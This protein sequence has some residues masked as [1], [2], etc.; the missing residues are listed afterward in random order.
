M[1]A[2]VVAARPLAL[3]AAG[4]G[5]VAPVFAPVISDVSVASRPAQPPDES[6]YVGRE[7]PDLLIR[8]SGGAIRLSKLWAQGPVVLSLVFA[9][10][11]GVCS[12]YLRALRAADAS[13]GSP[14]DLRRVVLSFDPRDTVADMEG[15]ARHLGVFGLDGWTFGIADPADIDRLSDALGFWFTWDDG[16]Q[17]F[18]HPAML[19]GIRR[20][21]VAR[22]LIGESVTP[23][24][25]AEVVR[26]GRGEFVASYPLPSAT[27]WRCFDYDPATGQA[28]LSWGALILIVP[29]LAAVTLTLGLFRRSVSSV[30]S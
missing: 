11:A 22:L 26:E 21:R 5:P 28:S 3:M 20:G 7:V 24:R 15:S 29:A 17:Q 4:P 13:I 23:A 27:R 18:D 12:P 16:R 10:C 8:T 2:L 9:R 30:S 14:S 19:A 1:T 6:R 25:L